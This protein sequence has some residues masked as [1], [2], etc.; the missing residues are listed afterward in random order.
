MKQNNIKGSL[1]LGTAALIWGLA[2]VAQSAATDFI[3]PFLIN[4]L[5]SFI[6]ALFLLIIL[7]IKKMRNKIPVFPVSKSQRLLTLKGGLLC[8][9]MLAISV[10]FQQFGL[11][12]YPKGVPTEARAGFLTALYVIL[13]PIL[14][15]F[16]KKKISS[17]VWIAVL[18]AML[19]I[20]MLCLSGGPDGI[21]LGDLLVFC[22]AISLSL[23][24]LTVDKYVSAI[25]GIRLSMLQFSVCAVISG[26]LSLIFELPRIELQNL[27]AATF[28]ILYLGIMSS[29]VGYTLQIIGQK[30]AEP[31]VAS[32]SMSLE[33]VFAALGGWVI[34][35]NSLLIREIIGC[36]L[37]FTAIL[38]AQ[39]PDIRNRYK[40]KKVG[41]Q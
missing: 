6:S 41:I 2:F 12:F 40:H 16:T 7:L 4:C 25:G 13:V 23:H 37:V 28:Q 31:S 14:S 19:G 34:S 1:L 5:R 39:M 20:Y 10:N 22:C 8:G 35:G 32:I 36:I 9:I 11:A 15:V 24:I 18:I 30:Y 29:G 38:L 26:I 17:K 27:L 33:S 3:P 21:Y